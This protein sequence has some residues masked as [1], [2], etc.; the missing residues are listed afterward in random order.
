M[1]EAPDPDEDYLDDLDGQLVCHSSDVMRRWV[2]DIDSEADR[3]CEKTY[4][5]NSPLRLHP[6]P[7][8]HRMERQYGS[9]ARA[10]T[11]TSTNQTRP[12]MPSEMMN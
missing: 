7:H 4:W 11:S 3:S 5:T 8:R 10:S 12:T 9:A 2:V 6:D 1:D